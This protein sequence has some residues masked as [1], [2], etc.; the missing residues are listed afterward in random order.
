MRVINKKYFQ[1]TVAVS[2][3]VSVLIHFPELV[4]LFGDRSQGTLFPGISLA[5]VLFEVG[6]AFV[7]LQIL[8]GVNTSLFGF[9]RPS[10]RMTWW[11]ILLSFML[12]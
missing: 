12:T 8:F 7:S 6:Y 2:L 9:N 11:K 5:D 3:T 10:A 4:S 1:L